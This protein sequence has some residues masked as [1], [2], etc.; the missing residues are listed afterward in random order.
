MAWIV[1]AKWAGALVLFSLFASPAV[2]Q[3]GNEPEVSSMLSSGLVKLGA[4]VQWVI[5]VRGAQA[6]ELIHVP[7]VDGLLMST[8]DRPS[9]SRQSFYRNG[10]SYSFTDYSWAIL[11]RP[12][13]LG[14]F[15]IPPARL[16]LDGREVSTDELTLKVVR[17]MRGEELGYFD[18]ADVPRRIYEGAALRAR[19]EFRLG[20]QAGRAARAPDLALVAT[21]AR[22]GRAQSTPARSQH[23]GDPL[24]PELPRSDPGR[25]G[26]DGDSSRHGAPG[27]P[28]A[29]QVPGDACRK[30]RI[31]REL[32]RVRR[33]L[34]D[35]PAGANLRRV[36]RASARA[37]RRGAGDSRGGATLRVDRGR[38]GVLRRPARRSA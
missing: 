35:E 26:G 25:R 31:P 5:Q 24:R 30:A 14:E 9:I 11:V 17:D 34:R 29:T 2:A 10:R 22:C 12:A 33:A 20:R 7:E 37:V 32:P 19:P 27:V 23:P 28:P 4:E 16:R 3:K 6:A 21:T 13:S 8:P 15:T 18:A 38:G 36:L 1:N